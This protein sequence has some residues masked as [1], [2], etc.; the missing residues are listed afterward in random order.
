MRTKQE[1]LLSIPFEYILG[2]IGVASL[3][4]GK[5]NYFTKK[6][7]IHSLIN[8]L[9]ITECINLYTN[10]QKHISYDD[11][12]KS[13]LYFHPTGDFLRDN[14]SNNVLNNDNESYITLYEF[15][16]P[17]TR[18]DIIRIGDLSFAYELKS[19]RDSFRRLNFQIKSLEKIFEI[20]Y[21][22]ISADLINECN[23]YID[24]S[25]GIYMYNIN[26]NK[27]M[28]ELYRGAQNSQFLNP[29]DQLEI[30]HK[31]EI[32]LIY[33]QIYDNK[34]IDSI[35]NMKEKILSY[36]SPSELNELFKVTMRNRYFYNI[37][38]CEKQSSLTF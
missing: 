24:D 19:T 22:V 38:Y 3:L 28:Y 2:F 14:F 37:N 34:L 35:I 15:P 26:E 8:S 18:A 21:I 36:H 4:R 1:Y 29:K 16:I 30:L 7:Y 33:E 31:S 32:K 11:A 23:K 12:A 5:T 25:V 9:S 6:D 13:Y 20:I 27:Y 17:K 10:Y